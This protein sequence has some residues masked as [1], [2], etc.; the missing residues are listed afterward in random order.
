MKRKGPAI[1][2]GTLVVFVIVDFDF[3][4]IADGLI[5]VSSRRDKCTRCSLWISGANKGVCDEA[6]QERILSIPD[7]A[8]LIS[9]DKKPSIGSR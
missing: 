1:E 9:G 5:E 8:S 7:C 6:S 4:L 2:G 3:I